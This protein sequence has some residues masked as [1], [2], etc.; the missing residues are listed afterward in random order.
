[1]WTHVTTS[2]GQIPRRET[3]GLQCRQIFNLIRKCQTALQNGCH[4]TR[5]SAMSSSPSGSPFLFA[6]SRYSLCVSF[7][8]LSTGCQICIFNK[9]CGWFLHISNHC[10]GCE[11]ESGCRGVPMTS[12]S[13]VSLQTWRISWIP[14]S[15]CWRRIPGP[16]PDLLNCHL[17]EYNLESVFS[18]N[19]LGDVLT[20]WGWKP[21]PS[22]LPD[23][24]VSLVCYSHRENLDADLGCWDGARAFS[25]ALINSATTCTCSL[26]SSVSSCVHDT[27]SPGEKDLGNWS[28]NVRPD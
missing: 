2:L 5:P 14:G 19:L 13:E 16:P 10:F 9:L 11:S 7:E 4:I 8:P 24:T 21:R 12:P 26:A 6:N 20:C 3:A 22:L 15:I 28:S 18:K 23:L 27:A 25:A 1:M 17:L